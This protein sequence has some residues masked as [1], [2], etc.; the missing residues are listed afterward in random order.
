ML[1]MIDFYALLRR[2][3]LTLKEHFQQG[4]ILGWLLCAIFPA[5][6]VSK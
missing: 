2:F 1:L 4:G 3:R 6:P 5:K